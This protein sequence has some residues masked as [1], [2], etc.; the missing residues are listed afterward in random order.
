MKRTLNKINKIFRDY[1]NNAEPQTIVEVNTAIYHAVS[2]RSAPNVDVINH[3]HRLCVTSRNEYERTNDIEP[4]KK[5]LEQIR[6]SCIPHR[7]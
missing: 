1:D 6:K 7:S 5:Q 2:D 4:M 3:I